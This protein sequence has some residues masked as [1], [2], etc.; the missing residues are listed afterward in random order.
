[1]AVGGGRPRVGGF[2][3]GSERPEDDDDDDDDDD[4]CINYYSQL[5]II[6]IVYAYLPACGY[7]DM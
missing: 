5:F 3:K 6:M 4:S 2:L 7:A 1:M